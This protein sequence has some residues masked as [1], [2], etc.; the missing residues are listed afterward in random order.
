MIIGLF[1]LI[2]FGIFM[3]GSETSKAANDDI[4]TALANYRSWGRVTKKPFTVNP[5]ANPDIVSLRANEEFK[6][7]GIN[8]AV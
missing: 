6:L 2:G 1:V 7:E 4:L 8:L 3:S 5:F